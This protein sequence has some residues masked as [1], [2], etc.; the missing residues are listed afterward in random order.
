MPKT[1][2]KYGEPLKSK[3]YNELTIDAA[4]QI[5]RAVQTHQDFKLIELRC[6]SEDENYS[7]I[8]VVDC[9]SDGIPSK[10]KI[11]IKYRERL[12]LQFYQNPDKL[13]EVRALR[14]NFPMTFHQHDVPS[15]EP[16][17]L[18]LYTEQWS[19]VERT[20][21]AQKHLSR[22]Q[23]WLEKMSCGKLHADDQPLEPFFFDSRHTL[24]LP[25]DFDDKIEKD[26]WS[27]VVEPRPLSDEDFRILVGRFEKN[28]G[29]V[30]TNELTL[31]YLVISLPPLTHGRIER[32]PST[33]GELHDQFAGR[34]V[35]FSDKLFKQIQTKV[36]A[37][38]IKI[39]K[40]YTFLVLQIPLTRRESS[41]IADIEK[42]QHKG[43]VLHEDLGT[44]G[45]T[46]GILF[47]DPDGNWAVP[48]VGDNTN[49][50]LQW[51][52]ITIEPL[53]IASPFTRTSARR[54]SGIASEGPVGV[55][56]GVGAL[57]SSIV[58][59]WYREGWG[60]WKLIDN[61][62]LK[63]HNLARHLAL[64]P[65]VGSYKVNAVKFIENCIYPHEV[66]A[67]QP[68]ADSVNNFSNTDVCNAVD[69][70]ALVVDVTTTLEVPRALS[71][72]ESIKRAASVFITPSGKDAVLLLED[73]KRNAKLD[74]LEAQ[75]FRSV[76]T[77]SW[78]KNHLKSDYGRYWVGAGCR[79]ISAIIAT[80]LIHVHAANIARQIRL[81]FENT[82][83]CIAIWRSDPESGRMD[84][85]NIII[86][87]PISIDLNR[88]TIIWDEGVRK[89][90]R[91]LRSKKLPDETGGIILGYFDLKLRRVYVVDVLPPPKDSQGDQKGFTR[92]IAGLEKAVQSASELTADMVGYIG[93]WH[94][95]P[96]GVATN[97]ST[98]NGVFLEHLA[99]ELYRDG[100]PGLMLIVGDEDERWLLAE[101]KE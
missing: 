92:G 85:E 54:A 21:T 72:R 87:A 57:G 25:T 48:L 94:S 79:D 1:Y 90:V 45:V 30:K 22:I 50:T 70:A 80:D 10:N 75:Y 96:S 31:S 86:D 60:T 71:T 38:G 63:P 56:A 51:R 3:R 35:N 33:L 37:S 29:T 40:G 84:V 74:V 43:F 44:I 65:H 89:K 14:L 46:G 39:K 76:I 53:E 97:P 34:G 55:L 18:C 88:L 24:I 61:D 6:L 73:S 91:E 64:E 42:I 59:L 17:S 20:W 100:L 36:A 11:G 98:Q 67:D 49:E 41:D 28:D 78:G 4:K 93:E 12:G 77:N 101:H 5:Y 7:E 26:E 83:S 47:K 2:I 82:T 9:T 15:S 16:L 58:N 95:H 62:I 13:P 69:S 52:D 32:I 99:L 66:Q 19:A 68:I 81:K 27:F 23:W 8:V